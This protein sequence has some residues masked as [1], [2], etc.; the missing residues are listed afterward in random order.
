[1]PAPSRFLALLLIVMSLLIVGCST[2]D[3][4]ERD[5]G[6]SVDDLTGADAQTLQEEYVGEEVS[7][8]GEISEILEPRAFVIDDDELLIVG[9]AGVNPEIGLEVRVTGTVRVMHRDIAERQGL[10]GSWITERAGEPV[11][12]AG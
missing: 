9:D 7:V 10:S 5:E 12:V 3:S 4:A 6:V 8:S 2:D 11:V 1:M